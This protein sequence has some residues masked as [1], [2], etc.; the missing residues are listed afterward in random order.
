MKCHHDPVQLH[1][2][3]QCILYERAKPVFVDIEPDTANIDPNL[4][5]DAIISR[6]VIRVGVDEPTP[7]RRS[8]VRDHVT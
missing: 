5:E 6:Y 8:A 1:C 4:V 3:Q 2:V 7:A